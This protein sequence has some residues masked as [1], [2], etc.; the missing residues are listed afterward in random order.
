VTHDLRR[1]RANNDACADRRLTIDVERRPRHRNVDQGRGVFASVRQ[2]QDRIP[3]AYP[4]D[5]VEVGDD[6]F[7]VLL[8][9]AN[10][11]QQLERLANDLLIF[12]ARQAAVTS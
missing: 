10:A 2:L 11:R 9:I 4:S 3:V 6:A 8:R 12:A 7:A 1:G 5:L